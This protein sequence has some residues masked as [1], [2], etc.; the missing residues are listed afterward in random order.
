MEQDTY[1]KSS[2]SIY[3]KVFYNST[4]SIQNHVYVHPNRGKHFYLGA[5]MSYIGSVEV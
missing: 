4:Y 3:E 2:V 1:C 5:K